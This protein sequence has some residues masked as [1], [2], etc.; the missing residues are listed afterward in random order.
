[1][2]ACRHRRAITQGRA[3]GVTA[4][5]ELMT[6][7]R[8]HGP[9]PLRAPLL[10]AQR[11]DG[12]ALHARRR[13]GH[14]LPDHRQLGGRPPGR[15]PP[16]GHGHRR[17]LHRPLQAGDRGRAASTSGPFPTDTDDGSLW[18]R[19]EHL[20]RRAVANPEALYPRFTGERDRTELA[21]LADP[22]SG[23][24]AFAAADELLDRWT[25]LVTFDPAPDVRPRWAR[26]YW[27]KRNQRAGLDVLAPAA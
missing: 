8:D 24:E 12:G 1:M 13:R 11:R 14:E 7:L 20:H 2:S 27:A 10:L 17:A 23:A 15:R 19:H 5:E 26:R 16:L 4:P 18:W 21:W 22:P 3:E 9:G 25:R 6:L